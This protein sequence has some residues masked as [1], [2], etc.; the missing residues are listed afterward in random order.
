MFSDWGFS[1][2]GW[3][4]NR[5]GE[6]WLLAQLLLIT[7]HLLPVWPAPA[8]FGVA[9]WPKPLFG[10][11]M[12]LLAFGLFRAL[13]AFRCLGASLSPLPAPKPANQLIATGTYAICR[14]PLYRAVLLCSAGVVL[15]TGSR[16][17]CCFWSAWRLCC[18]AKPA[19]RS[20]GCGCCIRITAN[21]PQSPRRLWA[22]FLAWTGAD[23]LAQAA[24]VLVCIRSA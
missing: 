19:S 16:C 20:R 17:I 13:E 5:R 18:G 1:W 14:H 7:A 4:D 6:W 10:L 2:G 12:L 22:G 8:S 9:I 21:T 11:G 3:L 24:T 23:G 15:A